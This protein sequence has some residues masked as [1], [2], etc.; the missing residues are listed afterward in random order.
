MTRST[1]LLLLLAAWGCM[2]LASVGVAASAFAQTPD[3]APKRVGLAELG[4]LPAGATLTDDTTL[5]LDL[6]AAKALARR[7]SPII[8][9]AA[10]GVD[11][12]RAKLAEAHSA[13]F[14]SIEATAFGTV[15][16]TKRAGASGA[17][18]LEDW[19]WTQ[20]K[21]LFTGQVSVTQPLYT[22][23]KLDALAQMARHGVQIAQATRRIVEAELDFQVERAWW[24]LVMAADL[25]DVVTKGRAQI[26]K[27]RDRLEALRDDD[28]EK[29]DPADL[30]KLRVV[31]VEFEDKVRSALRAR[32]LAQDALRF[33]IN[34]DAPWTIR[35]SLQ[36]MAAP[37]LEPLPVAAYETV[38]VANHPREVAR[39]GGL[40]LRIDQLRYERNKLLPDVV[41]T[42]RL[43]TT[44]A[45]GTQ[46]TNDSLA[47]NPT[48]PTQSGAGIAIRWRVDLFRQLDRIEQTAATMRQ[49]RARNEIERQKMRVDVRNS[50]REMIDLK[51]MAAFHDRALRATRGQMVA[52]T[53]MADKGLGSR[54]AAVGAIEQ[55]VR[56]RLAHADNLYRY[57]IAVAE[58]SRAIGVDVRS[59]PAPA[60]PDAAATPEGDTP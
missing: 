37:E 48:N 54:A 1:P 31:E 4:S 25:D 5:V 55:Y 35:P 34:L 11:N 22:F 43:A 59:M 19:D 30:V 13:W 32:A 47:D 45:P 9:S 50:V 23:G 10:A 29:F 3:S 12:V 44:Y 24:G 53:D 6:A 26:E 51:E 15:I 39:R 49:E 42:G 14:P 36:E 46:Q 57:Q 21:P 7:R 33:A 56:R 52:A 16:P 60:R 28:D 17:D 40:L 58:L 41:L 27:E 8:A 18:W 38:A 20:P 2:T